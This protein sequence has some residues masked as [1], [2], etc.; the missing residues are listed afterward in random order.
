MWLILDNTVTRATGLPTGGLP[1]TIRLEDI[2]FNANVA[3]T[4]PGLG[5]AL[6]VGGL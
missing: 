4:F 3:K 5:G 2:I 1:V 6:E